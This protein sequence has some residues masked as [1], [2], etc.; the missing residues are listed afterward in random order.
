MI[1]L[2]KRFQ[3]LTHQIKCKASNDLQDLYRSFAS[4]S[5]QIVNQ[6]EI[7]VAGLR[8]TGNH[9]I[10]SWIQEQQKLMGTVLHLNNLK[11]DE[12]PYRCKCQ[13]LSYY[14]SEH[15]WAIEQY[16]LQGRGH[17]S[18]RDCLIYSYEDYPIERIFSR[19]FER[20]HDLYLGK[21]QQRYDLLIIRDPFNLLASRL[22]NNF[23]AVKSKKHSFIDLWLDYAREYLGETNYLQHNKICVNYNLWTSDRNYRQNLAEKLNIDFN[24]TGIEVVHS[25][26]GGS[27]FD[28]KTLDGRASQMDV[29]G[30][31]KHFADNPVYLKMLDR[32][33]LLDYSYRI[34]G[35]ISG[36]EFLY[37]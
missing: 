20:K 1:Q 12:N 3:L 11:V 13:N 24:D 31:W 21:A 19:R 18:P 5:S 33:E 35:H 7:R 30:R 17:F 6:K 14:F 29:I 10:L 8:R 4:N 25:C 36:T 34:F 32:P 26:G 23:L 15:K 28:G 27:S 22:K 37:K 16:K 9:A 2:Q